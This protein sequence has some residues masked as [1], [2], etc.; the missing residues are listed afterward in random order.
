MSENRSLTHSNTTLRKNGIKTNFI[1]C[2]NVKEDRDEIRDLLDKC[3]AIQEES[4]TFLE[5]DSGEALLDYMQTGSADI[6][7]LDIYMDLLNGVQ[8]ARK[9]RELG[10]Q[11]GLVFISN[12][13]EYAVESYRVR[14]DYY[15]LKPLSYDDI[16]N[17]ITACLQKSVDS[18][19]IFSQTLTI[20]NQH[21]TIEIPQ[22]TITYIEISNRILTLHCIDK[23]FQTYGTLDSILKDLNSNYFIK[24][25]RSFVVNMYYIQSL[26]HDQII[27]KN[28]IALP[29]SRLNAKEITLKYQD[30]LDKL[31][32]EEEI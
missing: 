25:N 20:T 15:L 26:K 9:L 32:W 23:D 16:V 5:F 3:M 30:F 8:T 28:N 21:K 12:S 4:V 10:Y 24:P 6:I 19:K 2:D 18:S 13:S 31:L 22:V 1:I 27:L 29:L 7:F 17:A 11:S 14:A